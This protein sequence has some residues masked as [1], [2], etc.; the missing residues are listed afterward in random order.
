MAKL[1]FINSLAPQPSFRGVSTLEIGGWFTNW[2][3]S[4]SGDQDHFRKHVLLR[5]LHTFDELYL[6]MTLSSHNFFVLHFVD[7]WL[8]VWRRS[9]WLIISWNLCHTICWPC[10]TFKPCP[11]YPAANDLQA[12]RCWWFHASCDKVVCLDQ[13]T[14]TERNLWVKLTTVWWCFTSKGICELPFSN[15]QSSIFQLPCFMF[16][17]FMKHQ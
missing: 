7:F 6:W 1:S 5:Y 8:C 3:A 15:I 13:T 9:S 12:K 17:P 16:L 14:H 11:Y 2:T 10:V 4:L